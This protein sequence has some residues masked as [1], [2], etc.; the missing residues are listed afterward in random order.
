MSHALYRLGRL[1]ARR[2]WAVIGSW[3]VVSLLVVGASSA[4]GEK[5]EDSFGAPGLDSQKATDLLTD[6]GSDRAGLTA[7]VVL[8]PRDEDATFF[9][10]AEARAALAQVQAAVSTLPRVLAASD[11][12]GALEDGHAAAATAARLTRRS[13]R[14]DPGPVP[15]ARGARLR[16]PG[17][18]QG[19]RRGLQAGSVLQVELG[20]D[21][22]FAFEEPGTG[23]VR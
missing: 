17:E 9:D 4:F 19:A 16:R 13:G 21:L 5:L 12:A 1:A 15:G 7:Q 3:L 14:P 20:G 2:P 6:A 10:S 18:P 23:G 22:F 11:P 8:T